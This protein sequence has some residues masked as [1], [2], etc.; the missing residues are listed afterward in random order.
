MD[1]PNLPRIS[2][3]TLAALKSCPHKFNLVYMK[4]AQDERGAPPLQAGAAFAA[5]V[6]A[7]LQANGAASALAFGI[8]ALL[9]ELPDTFEPPRDPATLCEALVAYFDTWGSDGYRVVGS[10][11]TFA[12]PLP[13]NDPWGNPWIFEGRLD[14]IVEGPDGMWIR[15]EKT[16]TQLGPSW[17]QRWPLRSQFFA[18]MWGMRQ[19]GFPIQGVIVR[20]VG[21][22]RVQPPQCVESRVLYS[23]FMVERWLSNTIEWLK[24]LNRYI[25][26]GVFPM[27]MDDA[28][29]SYGGCPF[30]DS[31]L[32]KNPDEWLTLEAPSPAE[33]T[34]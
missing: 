7:V 9:K 26:T 13:V 20:G 31:C 12:W 32:A 33:K 24:N 10:E 22:Y 23:P 11:F 21:L 25:E 1:L 16:T 5:G 18:Y 27:A 17:P 30:R 6:Q 15:D 34:P 19:A 29:T 3:S 8:Q 28:C 14:S 4:G 2:S